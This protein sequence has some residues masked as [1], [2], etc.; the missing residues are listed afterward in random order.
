LHEF[1]RCYGEIQEDL[2]QSDGCAFVD[3]CLDS[4]SNR[5]VRDFRELLYRHPGGNALY[6]V[7]LLRAMQARGEVLCDETAT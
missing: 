4:Q 2:T 3:A 6:T 5:F 7:E 1:Q